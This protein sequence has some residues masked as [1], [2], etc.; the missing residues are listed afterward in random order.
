[1]PQI[2]HW[3]K[4]SASM[5]LVMGLALSSAVQSAQANWRS[6]IGIFRIGIIMQD[7]STEALDRLA[8]FKL[9]L[10][11]AL[12]MEVEY[13]R[14]R[15]TAALVDALASERIEYAIVSASGY[16][17]AW[18]S[19]EC[20]EPI[21]IPRSKDSTDGYHTILLASPQGPKTLQEIIGQNIGTLS[22]NSITG[23]A[24]V[25]H[26]LE[27]LNLTIGD[28]K[29][30]FVMSESAQSTLEAF[31][32]GE[33]K[34]L[35]AWSSM[36]GDPSTGYSRGNL[37]QLAQTYG[38]NVRNL[39]V[40]WKSQQIP[41]RPHIVRK[42]I[43]GEAKQILRNTLLQ[44]N[45]KDPIAYD[46]IEPVYGG[47]FGVGRHDRFAQIIDLMKAQMIVEDEPKP[48]AAQEEVPLQ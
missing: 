24:L 37:R 43:N 14:A 5:F 34:S 40:L 3:L 32:R 10:S 25:A 30:P 38:Q 15:N 7:Q 44:M 29:T 20:V 35:I 27:K 19:C 16:A 13:F 48:Q 8:P 12:D 41:H 45:E 31:S 11:E 4:I 46:S 6:D 23:Q 18:A 39:R 17:M 36:T 21:A 47:G 9:A 22:Q 1:M 26:E 2:Q 28:E 33:L 42:K